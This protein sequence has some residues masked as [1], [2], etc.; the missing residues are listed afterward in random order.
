MRSPA[1]RNTRSSLGITLGDRRCTEASDSTTAV[2]SRLQFSR[3]KPKVP[4]GVSTALVEV[5]VK[6]CEPSELVRFRFCANLLRFSPRGAVHKRD[7][8]AEVVSSLSIA[9]RYASRSG[10]ERP[11]TGGKMS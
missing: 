11:R 9:R 10:F 7:E 2:L 3:E 4:E 5:S 1:S 8:N 6:S